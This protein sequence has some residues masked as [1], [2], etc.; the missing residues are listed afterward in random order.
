[1]AVD[2]KRERE[3]GEYL[4][5]ELAVGGGGRLGAGLQADMRRWLAA[6][7]GRLARAGA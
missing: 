1:M 5:R 4:R 2:I 3:W 7:E 6:S